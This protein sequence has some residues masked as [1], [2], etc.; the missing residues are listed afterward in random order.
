MC[1]SCLQSTPLL[2]FKFRQQLVR[3]TCLFADSIEDQFASY[4]NETW[5]NGEH[6]VIVLVGVMA[7][8]L[9]L[10]GMIWRV[11]ISATPVLEEDLSAA[12]DSP[13]LP[14]SFEV[15]VSDGKWSPLTAARAI[16]QGV[17]A[18]E[19]MDSVDHNEVMEACIF[20]CL[21][22]RRRKLEGWAE[23]TNPPKRARVGRDGEHGAATL[24][25]DGTA[26]RILVCPVCGGP[27]RNPIDS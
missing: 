20:L 13:F 18:S 6:F 5:Q 22:A 16:S 23:P 10:V 17:R 12:I 2:P 11:V 15:T 26:G 21:S 27:G 1:T 9:A 24:A 3:S 4:A 25:V 19:S 8:T 7:V 14:A